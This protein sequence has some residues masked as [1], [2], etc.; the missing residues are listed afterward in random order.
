MRHIDASGNTVVINS[1]V[2]KL[3]YCGFFPSMYLKV[4]LV[5]HITA[6]ADGHCVSP[7]P[8]NSEVPHAFIVIHSLPMINHNIFIY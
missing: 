5:L 4:S 3:S 6:V 7:E 2:F 1:L 8:I